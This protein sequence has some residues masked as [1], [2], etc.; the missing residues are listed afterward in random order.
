M[1]RFDGSVSKGSRIRLGFLGPSGTQRRKVSMLMFLM[2]PPSLLAGL[3]ASPPPP[4]LSPSLCLS[5]GRARALSLPHA[6]KHI[7]THVL[8]VVAG[9]SI[10]VGLAKPDE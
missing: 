6:H 5:L 7:H 1:F 4:P 9:L 2:D 10:G 3:P 8:T